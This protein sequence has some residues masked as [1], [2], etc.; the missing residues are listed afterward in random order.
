[1]N[2]SKHKKDRTILDGVDEGKELKIYNQLWDI[3][4]E[5]YQETRAEI[6]G[7]SN[8]FLEEKEETR[9]KPSLL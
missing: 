7:D 1:M 5:L 6:E 3:M 8:S 4:R 2:G 9:S